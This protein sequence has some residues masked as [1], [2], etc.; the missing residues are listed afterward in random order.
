MYIIRIMRC[1][2]MGKNK[3]SIFRYQNNNI[4]DVGIFIKTIK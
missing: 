4:N 1:I 3:K 2:E